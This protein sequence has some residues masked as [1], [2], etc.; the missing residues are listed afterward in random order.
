[1]LALLIGALA[2]APVRAADPVGQFHVSVSAGD[3]ANRGTEQEPFHTLARAQAVVRDTI[4]RGISADVTV[5]IRGGN[6]YLEQPLVFDGRDSGR[7]IATQS[8]TSPPIP[9]GSLGLPVSRAGA[10][11][12]P[13]S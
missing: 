5:L 7:D 3:D 10:G 4:A 12:H 2:A 8:I 1:M 11:N 6:Y 9:P 13:V